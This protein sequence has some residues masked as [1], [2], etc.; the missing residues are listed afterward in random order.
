M[1]VR[2]YIYIISISYSYK[3]NITIMCTLINTLLVCCTLLVQTV[4]TEGVMA[5]YKGF[6]PNWLRLG[7]WNIIVSFHELPL[8]VVVDAGT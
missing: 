4:K 8:N 3:Y 2:L 6:I 7:P 1:P 5:L